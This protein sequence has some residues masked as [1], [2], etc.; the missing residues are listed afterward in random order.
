MHSLRNLVASSSKTLMACALAAL[1][2]AG[3]ASVERQPERP[4]VSLLELRHENVVVQKWDLSCGAAA[5]ATLL[6]YQHGDP[7]SEKAIAEAM[8]RSTNPLRV[9]VRG[10]FS[11][12]DLKRFVETRGLAGAG[13]SN[14]SLEQLIDLGP[15]IVPVDLSGYS[16][17]V[18]FRARIGNRVL[19]ADP[20]YGNRSLDAETFEKAWLR[21]IAFVVTRPDGTP[22]PNRLGPHTADLLF[23]SQRSIE[24]ALR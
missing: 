8:L 9:K 18:V 16:H 15:A 7:V 4:V 10:G 2:A 22:P 1:L 3:C 14:L 21:H 20:A 12:L 6:T 19:V 24:V 23:A 13:Y 11:L 5:L 17:F